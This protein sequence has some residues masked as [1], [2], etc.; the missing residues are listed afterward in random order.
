MQEREIFIPFTEGQNNYGPPITNVETTVP[1]VQVKNVAFRQSSIKSPNGS[2]RLLPS[3]GNS[4]ANCNK[5]AYY[6]NETDQSIWLYT[7]GDTVERVSRL[8]DYNGNGYFVSSGLSLDEITYNNNEEFSIAEFSD[9]VFVTSLSVD[10]FYLKGGAAYKIDFAGFGDVQARYVLYADDHLF[11]ANLRQNGTIRTYRILWSDLYHPLDLEV[12]ESKES[13]SFDIGFSDRQITGITSQRGAIM[14]YAQR[15]IWR[16][17][18]VGFADGIYK[19]S[20]LY[21]GLGNAYHGSVVSVKEND[22]FIDLDNIYILDGTTP[23]AI[24]DPIINFLRNTLSEVTSTTYVVGKLDESNDEVSWTY[25]ANGN[26][27]TTAGEKW[28]IVYNYKEDK[29]SNRSAFEVRDFNFFPYKVITGLTWEDMSE[30]WNSVA[31]YSKNWLD[32]SFESPYNAFILFE[33]DLHVVDK[34]KYSGPNDVERECELETF[35]M[36]L[37]TVFSEKLCIT[38]KLLYEGYEDQISSFNNLTL[39]LGGRDKYNEP[40]VWDE[41]VP[42]IELDH[43][44]FHAAFNVTKKFLRFKLT[45]TNSNDAFVNNIVGLSIKVSEPLSPNVDR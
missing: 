23:T 35:D 42:V 21:S 41:S 27:G 22:I 7:L 29:W 10:P 38:A 8:Y 3:G 33:N 13:G 4:M 28:Q 12:S 36:T 24:G 32:F 2:T 26:L 16:V 15:A 34:S 19:F 1:F 39:H 25:T 9:K 30:P 44:E 5:L 18:Y 45:W 14:I 20:R 40:V 43:D 37:G 6:T 31:Y 11:F 17:E